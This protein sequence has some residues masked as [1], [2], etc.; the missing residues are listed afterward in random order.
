M[1][2]ALPISNIPFILSFWLHTAGKVSIQEEIMG[3]RA[4][5][6]DYKFGNLSDLISN[7]GSFKADLANKFPLNI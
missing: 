2:S 7:S 5:Q 3:K 4:A 6:S 1:L